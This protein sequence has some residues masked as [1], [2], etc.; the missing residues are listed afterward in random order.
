MHKIPV[1]D[2][3]GEMDEAWALFIVLLVIFFLYEIHTVYAFSGMNL[4]QKFVEV[5]KVFCFRCM[6]GKL[7]ELAL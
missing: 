2:G 6:H 1:N 5:K 3:Y 7:K 4:R